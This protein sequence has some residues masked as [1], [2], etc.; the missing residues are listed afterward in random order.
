MTAAPGEWLARH[1]AGA[2]DA[3][4]QRVARYFDA[5]NDAELG[6]RLVRAAR[7]ALDDAV[8]LGAGRAAALD[9]LAADALITLALLAHAER[10]PARLGAIAVALRSEVIPAT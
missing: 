10:D 6:D 9:L 7:R 4:R 5:R 3:L 2:P 1:T 8:T